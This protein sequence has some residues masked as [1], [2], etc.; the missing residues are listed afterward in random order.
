MNYGILLLLWIVFPK[1]TST[2]SAADSSFALNL[3]W[4]LGLAI[5]AS[6][7]YCRLFHLGVFKKI[8]EG[9]A[10]VAISLLWAIA[11][12]VLKSS[13]LSFKG[14]VPNFTGQSMINLHSDEF[15]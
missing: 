2:A 3:Q 10:P 9:K 11:F 6:L 8:Y 7:Y 4:Q 15:F 12:T 13:E 5:F 1:L 14:I